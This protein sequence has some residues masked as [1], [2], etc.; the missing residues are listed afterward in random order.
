MDTCKRNLIE[1]SSVTKKYGSKVVLDNLNLSISSGEFV[2]VVGP[3]GCGKSTLVNILGLLDCHYEGTYLLG[4]Q[5]VYKAKEAVLSKM[6]NL[7]IGFIFQAYHL[8]E[9]MTVEDNILMPVTYFKKHVERDYYEYLLDMLGLNSLRKQVAVSLSGGEK[10]RVSIARAMINSPELII[11]DEPTGN[12]D[13][14][15]TDSV[16]SVLKKMNESGTTIVMVTHNDELAS[17]TTRQLVLNNGKLVE[18]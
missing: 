16:F 11:A 4:E 15:N 13:G 7:Q 17:K 12:L 6:R 18:G 9:Y 14:A 10:Q 2:S 8:I 5:P 1:L 3:S